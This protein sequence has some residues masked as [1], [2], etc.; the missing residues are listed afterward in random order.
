MEYASGRGLSNERREI[1]HGC[2]VWEVFFFFRPYGAS[3][4]FRQLT[5]GLRRG[6]HSGAASRLVG[7]GWSTPAA[8]AV[9]SCGGVNAALKAL[10]HPKA[11]RLKPSSFVAV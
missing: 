5:H 1:A 8:E 3:G 2:R 9:G 11:L 4:V 10:R 6:L 7:D